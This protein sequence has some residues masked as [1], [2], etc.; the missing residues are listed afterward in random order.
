MY[1]GKKDIGH[2]IHRLERMLGMTVSRS[3]AAYIKAEGMDEITFTHGWV[4][5]YLYDNASRN[6]FQKD[7]EK[8]FSIGRSTVTG[9]LQAL[10]KRGY[11]CRESVEHDA[12]LKR[13]RLTEKGMENVK[14]I[15]CFFMEFEEKLE[16]GISPEELEI[17]YQ[18]AEKLK[19]NLKQQRDECSAVDGGMPLPQCSP[20][21]YPKDI[22]K[23][24]I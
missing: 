24:H 12:R 7:I 17:F 19:N 9:M 5:K 10:E 14:A 8:N 23:P 21:A 4:L 11:L 15:G 6:V 20:H 1:C 13:V 18:V 22:L 3:M 2:E 16:A